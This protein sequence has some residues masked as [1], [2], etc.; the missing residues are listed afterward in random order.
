MCAPT[1]DAIRTFLGYNRQLSILHTLREG[2]K[3]A[4][5]LAKKGASKDSLVLLFRLKKLQ[6]IQWKKERKKKSDKNIV[7]HRM[8]KDHL[9]HHFSIPL[10][11][12]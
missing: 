10:F 8:H 9:I 7:L 12:C 11:N 3:C 2:N 4:D 5:S 1:V 6:N